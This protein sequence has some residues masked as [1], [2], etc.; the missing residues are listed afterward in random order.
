MAIVP[1]KEECAAT[2]YEE[3]TEKDGDEDIPRL[4]PGF[5]RKQHHD[6]GNDG[7]QEPLPKGMDEHPA[8]CLQAMFYE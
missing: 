6:A 5:F 1:F 4:C 2:N 3:C 7:Q 8:K